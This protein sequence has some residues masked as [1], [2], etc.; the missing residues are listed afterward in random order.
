MRGSSVAGGT[1]RQKQLQ[2]DVAQPSDGISDTRAGFDT[3][4]SE[5][6]QRL[7]CRRQRKHTWQ[8]ANRTQYPVP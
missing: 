5:G 6:A 1:R 4:E 2:L 8:R 3:L 7:Y